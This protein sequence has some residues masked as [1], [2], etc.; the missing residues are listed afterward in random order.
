MACFIKD[1]NENQKPGWVSCQV[2]YMGLGVSMYRILL[3]L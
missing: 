3:T 2:V 1:V